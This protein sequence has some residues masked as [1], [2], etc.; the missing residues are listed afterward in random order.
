MTKL[1]DFFFG[2]PCACQL[3]VFVSTV[4]EHS[5]DV[6]AHLQPHLYDDVARPLE[7]MSTVPCAYVTRLS[8]RYVGRHQQPSGLL[9]IF[10]VFSV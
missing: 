2:P 7:R 6:H 9:N 4:S 1:V 5:R 10:G 3:R 8:T